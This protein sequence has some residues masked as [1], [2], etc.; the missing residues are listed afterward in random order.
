MAG[1]R[2]AGDVYRIKTPRGAATI[3]EI[4]HDVTG[5]ST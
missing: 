2:R 1:L 4:F 3:P 5:G